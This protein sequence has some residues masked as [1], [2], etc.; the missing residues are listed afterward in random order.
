MPFRP[1][2]PLSQASLATGR[3]L[4]SRLTF[5]NMSRRIVVLRFSFYGV[6][7]T[8]GCRADEALQMHGG[9]GYMEEYLV[10]R[11]WRDCRALRI[12]A[13]TDEIMR[14]IIAKQLGL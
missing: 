2:R 7:I 14:E 5:R 3:R 12:A 4:T 8:N 1:M 6:Y 11:V 9:A 10:S 13:G